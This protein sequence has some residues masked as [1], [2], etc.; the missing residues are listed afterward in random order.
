[1]DITLRE[2]LQMAD[3]THNFVDKFA[4]G[5]KL[6]DLEE[7]VL[8]LQTHIKNIQSVARRMADVSNICN[9]MVL[10]NKKRDGSVKYINPYPTEND[11][12]VLR[13]NEPDEKK[14]IIDNV[15]IPVRH[16]KTTTEIPVS[17]IYY[18]ENIKQYV[19]NI[20]GVNIR[21]NLA[22]ICKYQHVKSARC[23]YGRLC[24][25][26]KN[27]TRCNYYHEPEDYIKTNMEVPDEPR[28]FTVGSWLYS[29]NRNPRT[30]FTRH[31]G[32]K[33]TLIRDLHMLK[34]IQYREEIS[35]REGQLIHDLLIYMILH[36]KG[37]LERYPHWNR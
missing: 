33:D 23:E 18:V 37:L 27:K 20:A 7:K 32:S 28:N 17:N 35:N 8:E 36:N 13:I 15:Y 11:H 16:V 10:Y 6:S 12:A 21:G 5:L 2:Y 25:S 9:Q 34:T 22:N 29:K 26:L 31:I 4:V 1:M 24:N 14:E 3:D 19:I 30:Y